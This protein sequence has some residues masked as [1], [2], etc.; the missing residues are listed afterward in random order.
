MGTAIYE[1]VR[2]PLT[3]IAFITLVAGGSYKL[4]SRLISARRAEAG[5]PLPD[6]PVGLGSIFQRVSPFSR[7]DVAQ[8]PAMA[9]TSL[10]FHVFLLLIPLFV[11]GHAVLWHESW[12]ISWWSLPEGIATTMT[13]AV[14][15]G[16]LFFALQWSTVPEVRA[17]TTRADWLLLVVALAPFLTGF[18]AKQQ[19]LPYKTVLIIHIVSG[20]L[21]LMLIPFSRL[22]RLL[23]FGFSK[24]YMR[25]EFDA[26]REAR[27]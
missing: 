3:W 27:D 2:G 24:A 23:W 8:H 26:T 11:M 25:A 10:V 1:L 20:C 18:L 13:L 6:G 14:L 21:W 5:R 12:G 7:S 16:G 15:V 19:V 17:L 4:R 22:F 9:L